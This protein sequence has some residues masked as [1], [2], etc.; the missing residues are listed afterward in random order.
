MYFIPTDA[1]VLRMK[2]VVGK[3]LLLASVGV[4]AGHLALFCKLSPKI[5]WLLSRRVSNQ[6]TNQSVSAA[7][8]MPGYLLTTSSSLWSPGAVMRS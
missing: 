7:T 5:D 1:D 4:S 6:K 8:C 2:A 3:V